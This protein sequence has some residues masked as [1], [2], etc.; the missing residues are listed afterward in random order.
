M[1][2]ITPVIIALFVFVYSCKKDEGPTVAESKETL[3]GLSSTVNSDLDQIFE[4]EGMDAMGAMIDFFNMDDPLGL[5]FELGLKKSTLP[6][7]SF[8]P[9]DLV[10]RFGVPGISDGGFSFDDLTG[11]YTWNPSVERWSVDAGNPSD[12]IVIIFPIE[13]YSDNAVFTIN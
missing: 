4:S 8:Q 10:K 2:I 7:M 3:K 13:G 11:T 5:D 9:S 1:K 6:D 12:K